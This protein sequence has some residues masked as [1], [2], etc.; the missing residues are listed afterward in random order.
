MDKKDEE[1][2]A[3][4]IVAVIAIL[5][6]ERVWTTKLRPWIDATWT[7]LADGAKI[8]ALPVLGEVDQTDLI[9]LGVLAVIVVIAVLVVRSHVKHTLK[10]RA[11]EKEN[12]ASR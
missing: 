2:L 4:L 6:V 1:E 7:D 8:A 10:T 5:V 9:G 11:Q 12:A 3:Y